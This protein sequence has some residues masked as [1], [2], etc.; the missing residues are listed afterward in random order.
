MRPGALHNILGRVDEAKVMVTV[1]QAAHAHILTLRWVLCYR[2]CGG[3][4]TAGMEGTVE[5]RV[6]ALYSVP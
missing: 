6:A 5:A 1:C 4:A 2:Y 3:A